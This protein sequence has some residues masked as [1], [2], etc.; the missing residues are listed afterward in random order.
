MEQ[1]R[2]FAEDASMRRLTLPWSS[3]FKMCWENLKNRRGRFLLV[4]ASIAVVVAFFVNTMAYQRLLFNLRS[5]ADISTKAALERAGLWSNNPDAEKAQHD[6]MIW[7]LTLSGMLCFV[8]V[9]NT[10]FMSVT[11]RYREIGTLKCLGALNS[12]VVRLFLIES[13]FVGITGSVIGSMAGLLLT[14]IQAG[15]AIPFRHLS[16][17]AVFDSLAL[18]VP[19]AIAGG[20]LLTMLAA[21][22]PTMEA[23]RMRPVDAMRAE[24]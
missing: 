24:V 1:K 14:L 19:L 22:Y 3:T 20:T 21:I 15:L 8:G 4:F 11:E 23:A 7:L 6:R 9:T 5:H 18:T 12:F 16:G 13:L 10:M 2:I 17:A